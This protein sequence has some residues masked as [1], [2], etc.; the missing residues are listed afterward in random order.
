MLG[1]TLTLKGLLRSGSANGL[2]SKSDISRS[3]SPTRP[4][5]RE[6]EREE[7][8]PPPPCA[9]TSPQPP[10]PPSRS[11]CSSRGHPAGL[12]TEH[13]RCDGLADAGAAPSSPSRSSGPHS[14]TP[15]FK[16]ERVGTRGG[17]SWERWEERGGV[18]C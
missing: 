16:Y 6:R 9:L 17:G 8:R 4:K 13:A 5:R 12:A 2:L 3:A 11:G 7:A 18:L 14:S 10:P 1:T 15:G